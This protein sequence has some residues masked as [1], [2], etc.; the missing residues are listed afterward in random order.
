MRGEGGG[1]RGTYS[2]ATIVHGLPRELA[3][4]PTLSFVVSIIN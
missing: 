4:S 2:M 1:R 3:A